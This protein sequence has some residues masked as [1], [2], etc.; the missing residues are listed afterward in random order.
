MSVVILAC[1]LVHAFFAPTLSATGS[2]IGTEA[3]VWRQGVLVS[4][5]TAPTAFNAHGEPTNGG[6]CDL[7]KSDITEQAAAYGVQPTFFAVSNDSLV[8][9]WAIADCM[10]EITTFVRNET[11]AGTRVLIDLTTL[12]DDTQNEPSFAGI[13]T[14]HPDYQ[15]RASA[16]YARM[17]T[18]STYFSANELLGLV[19]HAETHGDCLSG[20]C[21]DNSEMNLAI[22]NGTALWTAGPNWSAVDTVAGF[23]LKEDFFPRYGNP[24]Q[25][26]W[27]LDVAVMYSYQTFNPNQ[28]THSLN[29]GEFFETIDEFASHVNSGRVQKVALNVRGYLGNTDESEG[30]SPNSVR[31]SQLAW[32]RWANAQTHFPIVWTSLWTWRHYPQ[33]VDDIRGLEWLNQFGHPDQ[34]AQTEEYF[35]LARGLEPAGNCAIE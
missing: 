17:L 33:D 7:D 15:E 1:A 22:K 4:Y 29:Y 5:L 13:N 26:P 25:L 21:W 24:P 3:G 20:N 35:Q 32:C 11:P 2:G 12:F 28:E 31:W 10:D 8:D 18:N 19:I 16:W 9:V 23:P 30:W 34:E 6:G 14:L 27:R